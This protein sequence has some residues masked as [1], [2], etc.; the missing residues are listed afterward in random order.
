MDAELRRHRHHLE[1]LVAERTA[2]LEAANRAKS[3]F[4]AN[5]S[6]E[7]RTPMNAIIGL[8]HLARRASADPRQQQ[9][10][11]KVSAAADH[12]LSVLNDI[13]D[14]SKIEAGKVQLEQTDFELARV[15]E[16][17]LTLV[18][19][20]A[21]QKGLTLVTRIDPGLPA[22]LRGDPLRLG[23]ILVNYAS[24]AVKF[25]E[26]GSVTL[27]AQRQAADAAGWRLRFEV[28]DT[29][30]GIAAD[31]QRR[32][33][34]VFEQADVSMTRRYGGTGLG[35]AICKRL[36]QLMDGEVG[37]DSRPGVGSRFWFTA[38]FGL[39]GPAAGEV[40]AAA[41]RESPE[42]ALLRR[43]AGTRVLLV[44][45]NEVNQEV[46]RELLSEI[47][48]VVALAANGR[49]AVA[50][51]TQAFYDLVLM[52]VQMPQMDGLEATLAIRR[53]PGWA[54]T[55]ILAMTANAFDEDRERC[56][57]AGMSDY[58]T[59]PV[60]PPVLYA[61]ILEWLPVPA[62]AGAAA[63]T[64]ASELSSPLSSLDAVAGLD[65]EQG[66]ANT[67]AK[68][69]SYVRLLRKYLALHGDSI[70]ELRR[71]LAA[72]RRAE[73][74][75]RVHSLKGAS[76]TLGATQVSAAA[77]A[78]EDALSED[79]PAGDLEAA[80]AAVE[81]TLA[82]FSASL[83]AGLNEDADAGDG[84]AGAQTETVRR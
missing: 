68:L 22:M 79:P 53:L 2:Q 51:A 84:R 50:M 35:L 52:D 80:T 44:E 73:A 76:A 14:I 75:R 32:L 29:G 66:L 61:K 57:A 4:L 38:R 20:Q 10:L 17:V 16:N 34:N 6:H 23:Q 41:A 45:D 13:L 74:L 7:I 42:Q 64:A 3:T 21:R 46:M 72:G 5:M 30:V 43:Q 8:T 1:E 12:L 49:E 83:T 82:T 47:G 24:N 11:D 19:D 33:F 9:Y 65:F 81:Q 25:T 36:A 54:D 71:E 26:A 70:R 39:A 31:A 55:P 27:T 78:L 28:S 63:Q 56:L 77:A 67:G 59:K 15:V 48:F 58:L 62:A 37:V 40:A 60:A 69:H 18:G